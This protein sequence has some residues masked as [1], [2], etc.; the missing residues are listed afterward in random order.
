MIWFFLAL[1]SG[2]TVL[3]WSADRFVA[4][5][6]GLARALGVSTLIIGLTIVAF[7]TSAPEM[8]VSAVA[9][10]QG[11]A[12]LAIGN[13][14]GSNIANMALVLGVTA[15]I[16]PLVVHS[17]TLNR[18]F[19]LML[20]VMVVALGLLWNGLL[21]RL[22]GLILLG[23]MVAVVVWTIH[24]ARTSSV[25]DPLIEELAEEIPAHMPKGQAWWLLVSGL[26][27]L[28]L[29]SKLLVWGAVGIAQYYGVSDLVIGLT[30]VAIG[31]SLPELAASVMAARKNEHDIA[32]GNVVGSNLFNI[33]AVLGI[34]GSIAPTEVDPAVLYRDFPLMLILSMAL[35]LMARG[36]SREGHGI[37][38]R[39]AGLLLLLVFLGYQTSLF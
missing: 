7:G 22:D 12:G 9:A 18:E 28:L 26:A 17:N 16:A 23:G 4:G 33:L 8:L 32:V 34:A 5:A 35:Y 31:T 10:L 3:V 15:L 20:V 6:A 11:N 19:P 21:S 29:S 1:I 30:I 14:I 39:W 37:I 2:L 13:A 36:F 25:E 27:L 38:R 24:L